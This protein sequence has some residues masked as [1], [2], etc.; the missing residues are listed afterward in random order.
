MAYQ[1]RNSRQAPPP[2]AV[3]P[4]SGRLVRALRLRRQLT[5]DQLAE[6]TALSKGHLS[7]FERGEKALSIAALV[8]VAQA[9]H[10]SVA[11][12]LGEQVGE[13]ILHVVRASERQLR[14]VNAGKYTFAP[15][16]RADGNES[17]T[18]FLLQL[19][20]ESVFGEEA[21]HGG[22]EIFFVLSG[23]I[24]IELAAH[25]VILRQGD[26]AQFPGLVRHRLRGVE[27]KTEVL[28]IVADN[29]AGG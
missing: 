25:S 26:Y 22:D 3:I 20:A 10:T 7:R 2:D 13:D 27:P 24:E 15:L 17:P 11:S 1:T 19:S 23:A 9:L 29:K 6:E 18:A 14:R 16:S 8:R 5:L 21:F 28:I 4:A 12:L